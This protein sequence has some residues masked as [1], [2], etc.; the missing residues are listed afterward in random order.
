M[1]FED[2]RQLFSQEDIIQHIKNVSKSTIINNQK[3]ICNAKREFLFKIEK[4]IL[5]NATKLCGN[6]I[7]DYNCPLNDFC[8]QNEI[9]LLVS[10][11]YPKF[12]VIGSD[13]HQIII[14]FDKFL[15]NLEEMRF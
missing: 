1:K 2:N 3:I 7:V 15:T 11:Q 4:T 6:A 9:I 12:V 5:E 10:E 14:V 13:E 8:T